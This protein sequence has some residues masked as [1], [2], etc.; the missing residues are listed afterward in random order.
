MYVNKGILYITNPPR[1][2]KPLQILLFC[3]HVCLE[4]YSYFISIELAADNNKPKQRIED[5]FG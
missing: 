2:K 5:T 1:F 3:L 4:M